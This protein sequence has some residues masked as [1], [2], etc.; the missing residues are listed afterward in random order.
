MVTFLL[1][2]YYVE[3]A[4]LSYPHPGYHLLSVATDPMISQ[5]KAYDSHIKTML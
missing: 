4:L 3:A 2:H 1:F 5:L